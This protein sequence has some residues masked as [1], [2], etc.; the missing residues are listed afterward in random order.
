MT[1]RQFIRARSDAAKREREDAILEAARALARTRGVREITLTDIAESAGMHKSAMLRYFETREEIFLQLTAAGWR[2]WSADVRAAL[3]EARLG[4][5]H[6][7]A[8]V[9]ARTLASRGTFCDLLAQAPMNLE[10]RVSVDAVRRFKAVT[11]A[12]LASIVTEI[13]RILPELSREHGVDLIAAVTALAGVFW[14]IATPSHE[15]AELYRTDPLLGH[16]VLE[17]GPRLKRLAT[18][19]LEGMR[20]GG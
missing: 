11:H 15:V 17:V 1:E 20:A 18:Y 3:A 4:D 9:L 16:D 7:V 8:D 10:R 2:E 14:Q 19:L 6:T 13:Q 12:E 5:V